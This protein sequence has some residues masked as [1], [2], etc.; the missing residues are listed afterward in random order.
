MKLCH[1]IFLLLVGFISA[2]ISA[3]EDKKCRD[4]ELVRLAEENCTIVQGL[5]AGADSCKAFS[6]IVDVCATEGV[7][8]AQIVK[9]RETMKQTNR[10]LKGGVADTK[11]QLKSY[12]K[13]QRDDYEK[14]RKTCQNAELNSALDEYV[15]YAAAYSIA[16]EYLQICREQKEDRFF[17]D[18]LA[19]QIRSEL[20]TARFKNKKSPNLQPYID[21]CKDGDVRAAAEA[22]LA[23]LAVLK[24]RSADKILVAGGYN[25]LEQVL[26]QLDRHT[27]SE[28]LEKL[29]GLKEGFIRA[30]KAIEIMKSLRKN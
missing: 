11:G 19:I 18:S 15:E 1:P 2:E 14:F 17:T 10:Q 30:Q 12:E 7:S 26:F 8:D 27:K 20:R 9:L 6:A 23:E 28:N 21:A 3:T 4:A 25:S 29:T 24:H 13:Q 16:I 5:G 22:T